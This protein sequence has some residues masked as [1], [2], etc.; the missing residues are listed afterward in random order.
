MI[1]IDFDNSPHVP[2]LSP[3][4]HALRDEGMEVLCTARDYTQTI[5]LLEQSGLPYLHVGRSF[6]KKK[7]VKAASLALRLAQLY[8]A[9]RNKPIQLAVNHGSRTQTACA[10]MLGLPS[11]V[12]ADYEYTDV[13]VFRRF[14]TK[15]CTP[16]II[17]SENLTSLGF[18]NE[19]ITQY[20]GFKE[21][22]YLENFQPEP[23]FRRKHRLPKDK[24][25]VTLRPPGTAGNYHDARSEKLCFT[26]LERLISSEKYY[27]V[28]LPKNP[29]E[30]RDF[31]AFLKEKARFDN[32]I[33]PENPL[34]GLQLIWHSDVV[35]SG[36][37]TMNREGALLNVPTYSIF[38]ARKGAVDQHLEKEKKLSFLDSTDDINKLP[39]AKRE[40]PTHFTFAL[41]SVREEIVRKIID[42]ATKGKKSFEPI[43]RD[44]QNVILQES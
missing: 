34:P 33:I 8:A 2:L 37:G 1:W 19:Q 5:A 27:T 26:L 14:A 36:G 7:L 28:L 6:G 20:D 41:P 43:R 30:K 23:G 32:W 35:V 15:F 44:S 40:I 39:L 31:L 9:V 42:M 16:K 18:E 3:I 10:R 22:I 17:P 11:L 21:C 25:L 12:M 29:F 24:I 38:T 4:V 13:S